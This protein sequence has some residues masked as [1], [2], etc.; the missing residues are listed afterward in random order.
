MPTSWKR[1]CRSSAFLPDKLSLSCPLSPTYTLTHRLSLVLEAGS[2]KE[3]PGAGD[4]EPRGGEGEAGAREG[5][6]EAPQ[7]QADR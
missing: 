2:Q 6:G 1:P 3:S 7:R 5:E 4:E